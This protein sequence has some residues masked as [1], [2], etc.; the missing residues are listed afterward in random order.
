MDVSIH[1]EVRS[2]RTR[3][4]LTCYLVGKGRPFGLLTDPESFWGGGRRRE[5]GGGGKACRQ[6][7]RSKS[8]DP[9]WQPL[10]I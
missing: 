4:T 3:G 6:P 8:H 9:P 7:V 10:V 5:E 2:E 1:H